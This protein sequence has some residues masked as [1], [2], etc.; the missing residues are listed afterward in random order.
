MQLNLSQALGAF[1]GVL[2]LGGAVLTM[3]AVSPAK[4]PVAIDVQRI[5]VREPDGTLRMVISNAA[6]A[7]GIIVRGRERPHP[8][9]RSAG[10]IFYNDEG[11]ENGGLIFDGGRDASGARH[12]HG[13][14]S[15]DRYEQD[16]VVQLEASEDGPDR[17]AGLAFNDRPDQTIDWAAGERAGALTGAARAA[18]IAKAHIGVAQRAFIGRTASGVLEVVLRDAAGRKRLVLG[19]APSGTARISFLDANGRVTRTIAAGS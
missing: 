6:D 7:P 4:A 5:N 13:H 3:G 9:R 17:S 18:E 15:F 11:T 19:V 10:I 16:Q 8:D 1:M 14:L 12:S 2:V